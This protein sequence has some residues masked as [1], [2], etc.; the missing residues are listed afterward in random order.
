MNSR[1]KTSTL[2]KSR[3]ANRIKHI[4][5]A[6]LD[7][8]PIS[9]FTH[10]FYR[11]PARF[12][13]RFVRTAI[14][15]FSSPGDIVLDPYM[16]GGTTIVEAYATGRRS[17][18]NDVNSLAVFVTGVKIATLTS[19]EQSTIREWACET[20]QSLRCSEP[21]IHGC[22]GTDRIPRNMSMFQLR[23]I[24]KTITQC[25]ATIES[26]IGTARARRFATCVVLNVGQWALNGR[27]NIPT[28]YEF[29]ARIE[30]TAIDMLQGM[31]ELRRALKA[32]ATTPF[33]PFL[34]EGDAENLDSINSV[35]KVGLADLVVTSPPY[36]GIHMLYHRWQVDG[37]KESDAP[38]WIANTNDGAGVAYYNFA[39]RYRENENQY[40]DKAERTFSSV[41][42]VM[43]DGAVLVQLISFSDSQRQLRR[44]L[45]MLDSVGFREVRRKRT[46]R[47]WREVP[48]R[49][50]HAHLKGEIS[51]SKEVALIHCAI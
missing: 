22:R 12:S 46:R 51:S 30:I 2:R 13:P 20:V 27:K 10:K 15:V 29:R 9:G 3:I 33:K 21:L 5:N 7:Q 31:L 40:F 44:Y 1:R 36:P 18:G 16:G 14:E 34:V 24:R 26:D 37:R 17:I 49:R 25:L 39:D 38:Y 50:W 45:K 48:R 42:N 43:R 6:V 23:W 35:R 8:K 4:K 19:G 32:S 28:V 11:Y 47:I 41:R